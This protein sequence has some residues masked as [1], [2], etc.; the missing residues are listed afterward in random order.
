MPVARKIPAEVICVQEHGNGVFTVQMRPDSKAPRFRAGQF[1]HFALDAYDPSAPWPESRVFSIANSPSSRDLIRITYTIK[2]KYTERMAREIAVGSKVWLKLPYGS[3]RL[4]P[5]NGKEI[6]L[7]AGG[8]GITP[9]ISFLEQACAEGYSNAI[10]LFYGVRSPEHILYEDVFEQSGKSLEDF[11]C[12][13]FVEETAKVPEG[14]LRGSL[15]LDRILSRIQSVKTC[16]FYLSGPPAMIKAFQ[17]GLAER[18]VDAQNVR[19]D[20]WE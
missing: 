3:F 19:I 18:G 11:S 20:D 4:Q 5:E 16:I 2:G 7:V 15:D 1:L 17:A 12:S 9:F 8:T 14:A 6:A 10:R 13:V